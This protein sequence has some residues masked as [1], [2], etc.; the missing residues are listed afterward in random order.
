MLRREFL[1]RAL[2]LAGAS[3]GWVQ[4]A[5]SAAFAYAPVVPGAALQFPRDYGAHPE[6]RIEWWYVTGWLDRSGPAVAPPCGFQV[7]FFRVRTPLQAR[8][9]LARR[10]PGAKCGR[11][12]GR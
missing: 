6:H 2:L 11:R 3:S 12:A 1:Q 8:S 5:R 7:T 9:L 4:P 10:V